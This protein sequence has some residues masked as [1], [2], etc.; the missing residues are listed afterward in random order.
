MG[1]GLVLALACE[2]LLVAHVAAGAA[3]WFAFG[4]CAAAGAQVYGVAAGA[5]PPAL[6]ARVMTAL[7]L[8]AF[9]GAFAIQWGVGAAVQALG[10][11]GTSAP[12]AFQIT[13]G[14]LL[15]AKALA[16]L[17]SLRA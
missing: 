12:A 3:A 9:V 2:A 4:A 1:A 10:G 11:A 8:M 5:F 6:S 15:G 16:V 14:V 17:W 7:N 13:L